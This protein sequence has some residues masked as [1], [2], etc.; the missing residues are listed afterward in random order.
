MELAGGVCTPVLKVK[1]GINNVH[2]TQLLPAP[3]SPNH[4]TGGQDGTSFSPKIPVTSFAT[5]GG[6]G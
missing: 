4:N 2:V 5:A 6:R 3:P 1:S